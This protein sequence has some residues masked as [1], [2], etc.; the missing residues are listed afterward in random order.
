MSVLGPQDALVGPS[1]LAND[2]G[3]VFSL[4]D[5]TM[6]VDDCLLDEERDLICGT[7]IVY[8]GTFLH[9]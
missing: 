8:T 6:L 1:D 9:L 4:P 2:F 5:G 7:Y 3:K